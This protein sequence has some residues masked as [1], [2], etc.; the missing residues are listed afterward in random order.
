MKAIGY[1]HSQLIENKDS[2]V[3]IVI[4]MPQAKGRDLLVKVQ[5]VS[6]PG[7]LRVLVQMLNIS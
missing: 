3:D 1:L 7:I 2:L 5:A 4:E 6:V